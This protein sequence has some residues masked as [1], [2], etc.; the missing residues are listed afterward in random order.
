MALQTA[1]VVRSTSWEI[2]VPLGTYAPS[3]II[4]EGVSL[5][6]PRRV[7]GRFY[8]PPTCAGWITVCSQR[9]GRMILARAQAQGPLRGVP[10]PSNMGSLRDC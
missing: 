3:Q 9:Y 1:V 4:R 2:S 6:E 8:G 10:S 5:A 7:S